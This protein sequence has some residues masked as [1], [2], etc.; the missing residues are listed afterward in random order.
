MYMHTETV[1]Y[2]GPE[3][4]CGQSWTGQRSASYGMER[5]EV[6]AP[7]FLLLLRTPLQNADPWRC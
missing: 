4:L 2:I 1:Q 3:F 7:V 5:T 6:I